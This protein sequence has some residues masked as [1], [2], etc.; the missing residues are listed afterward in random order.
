[1]PEPQPRSIP[2]RAGETNDRLPVP[3]GTTVY[4]RT[5]GGNCHRTPATSRL[6][7]LS[8]HGRGKPN[9]AIRTCAG[10]GSIP[11]RAG[12]TTWRG[13]ITS[14][15]TVYPRTGG[16]N[17]LA[18]STATV[19]SGLSPHGRGKLRV[20]RAVN[21]VIRSIPARAG[22]TPSPR[23]KPSSGTVYPRTG[24]G[25][26]GSSGNFGCSIGLSPHG[27]GKRLR[28]YCGGFGSRS[29]PARAG[30]TRPRLFRG[31]HQQV[32]PRTGGGNVGRRW[33]RVAGIGL[34]PHGRGKHLL[35]AQQR[36]SF[37]S[38]PARAGETLEQLQRKLQRK[39]YPRT[40]GGNCTASGKRTPSWGLSP[41]GRGKPA[42]GYKYAT[43]RRS[44]PA[45]AGETHQQEQANRIQTVYPRTG[46]GNALELST[47]CCRNGLSPHG[48]GK[49]LL[50]AAG[51][52]TGGSIPARAG[53]TGLELAIVHLFKVYPRTGGGNLQPP[54]LLPQSWGLSPHGR[55]K[56]DR[57]GT[58]AR[59]IGLSPHGRGK[60]DAANSGRAT[61]GSIPARAGETA[62]RP[63]IE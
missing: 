60:P 46:G 63:H 22:E 62:A 2:A 32:Y 3:A 37:G 61:D 45:R 42:G 51:R 54:D 44:I 14:W 59:I 10:A 38:I 35:L 11:A 17:G 52:I 28:C 16:G 8:P 23:W 57:Y 12:E 20:I 40:G 53:E 4:P 29:I 5:G 24:G 58:S 36:I 39:V 19:S 9:S 41:H 34:S 48:R 7:G 1:M 15:L 33:F 30:E 47:S 55:G 49:R 18:N 43:V 31:N 25:N 26:T 56:P 21:A 6:R 27:R 13:R 50:T